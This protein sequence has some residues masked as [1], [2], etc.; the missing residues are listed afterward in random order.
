M[1]LIN[2]TPHDI[3]IST[4]AGWVDVPRSGLIAR[5]ETSRVVVGYLGDIVLRRPT[6]GVTINL[7]AFVPSVILIVSADVA[8]ANPTRDD[9]AFPGELIRDDKGQTTG[10]DGLSVIRKDAQA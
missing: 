7:P 8:R 3:R 2:C 10:C 4:D 5:L 1:T 6:F 9:L